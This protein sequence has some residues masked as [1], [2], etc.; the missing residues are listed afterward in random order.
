MYVEH[1]FSNRGVLAENSAAELPQGFETLLASL[2]HN[3]GW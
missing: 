3:G 1:M 2:S